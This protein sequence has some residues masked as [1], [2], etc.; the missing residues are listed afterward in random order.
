[1][2]DILGTVWFL[3]VCTSVAM[4]LGWVPVPA[5]LSAALQRLTK[6]NPDLFNSIRAASPPDQIE[7]MRAN[8]AATTRYAAGENDMAKGQ[9]R[10]WRRQE[11]C[12]VKPDASVTDWAGVVANLSTNGDGYGVVAVR[13]APYITLKTWNNA[14]SDIG[15]KTLIPPQ[16]A[17]FA[18]AVALKEGQKVRF[19]GSLIQSKLDCFRESSMSLEGSIT[20]PEY[21]LVFSAIRPD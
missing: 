5:Q 8:E 13:I 11:L 16:S 19:S 14:F 1:M 7:F 9:A 15:D 3:I 20:D 6:G 2:K 17:L 21:I 10:D 18:S 12:R 4:W